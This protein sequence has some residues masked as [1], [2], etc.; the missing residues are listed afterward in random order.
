MNL[1]EQT[2]LFIE[3]SVKRFYYKAI[4]L[5]AKYQK[6]EHIGANVYVV[7]IG[8]MELTY[9]GTVD[10]TARLIGSSGDVF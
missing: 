5:G 9:M 7:T 4:E 10:G 2:K 6:A 3:I 8:N 1:F